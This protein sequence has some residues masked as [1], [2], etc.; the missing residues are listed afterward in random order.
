MIIYAPFLQYLSIIASASDR[1]SALLLEERKSSQGWHDFH[2]SEDAQ[3]MIVVVFS[4]AFLEAYIF[5]YGSRALGAAFIERHIEK[6][7]VVSKWLL[8][9]QLATGVAFRRDLPALEV[10]GQI[11]RARN[12][13]V[14]VKSGVLPDQE[15]LREKGRKSTAA[16][17]ALIQAAMN[18]PFCLKHLGSALHRIDP[19]E[20]F[21][22]YLANTFKAAVRCKVRV[23]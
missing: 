9:P 2:E 4:A 21:A 14:H 23:P 1:L 13:L 17:S 10:L 18:S 20:P 22:L 15:A 16:R 5:N 3:A 19:Q 7:D 12:D 6:L 8:V 11:V